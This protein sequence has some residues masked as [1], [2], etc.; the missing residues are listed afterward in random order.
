MT[1]AE[2]VLQTPHGSGEVNLW[3]PHGHVAYVDVTAQVSAIIEEVGEGSNATAS[4][5]PACSRTVSLF[6]SLL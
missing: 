5:V 2:V 3:L 6:F 1:G 4:S